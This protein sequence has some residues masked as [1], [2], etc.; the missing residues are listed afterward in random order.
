MSF[1]GQPDSL[2][3]KQLNIRL[4]STGSTTAKN[5]LNGKKLMVLTNQDKL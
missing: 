5:F 3:Q 4:Q 1:Y 2:Q